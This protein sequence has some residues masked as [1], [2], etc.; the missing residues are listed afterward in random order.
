MKPSQPFLDF[1]APVAPQRVTMAPSAIE[2]RRSGLR[3][4]RANATPQMA[5]YR[6][7]L[8]QCGPLSDHEAARILGWPLATVCGRRNDCIQLWRECIGTSGRI[9]VTHPD[10]RQSS[11]TLWAWIGD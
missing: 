8:E 5:E 9:H 11:R 1:T 7:V 3:A 6:A 2:A 4:A 10:G